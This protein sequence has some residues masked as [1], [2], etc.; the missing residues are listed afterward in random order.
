VHSAPERRLASSLA[1]HQAFRQGSGAAVIGY[2]QGA[3]VFSL[4]DE[5]TDVVV[6]K[7]AALAR[8]G[9]LNSS[10]CSVARDCSMVASAL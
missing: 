6:I 4:L 3:L 5:K 7:V 2:L 9:N 1:G 10:C 8:N